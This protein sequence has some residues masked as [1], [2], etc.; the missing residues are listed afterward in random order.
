[1]SRRS[2]PRLAEEAAVRI[3]GMDSQGRPISVATSTLDISRTGVR[4]GGVRC[5]GF[6]GEIIGVRHGTEK[7]RF[8]IVWIGAPG[9]Q[10][11]GQIGLQCVEIGRYIF[12]VTLP[13]T[14]TRPEIA[15]FESQRTGGNQIGMLS[16]QHSGP[17]HR[18]RE[19]RYDVGG[20]VNIREIGVGVPQWAMLHDISTG[21]CYVE[22]TSPLPPL[23]RAELT[24]QVGDYRI[25]CKG[26]VTV[27]HPLVGMGI[28]FTDMTAVNRDR[29]IHLIDSLE[30]QS[31]KA[32]GAF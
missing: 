7:A 27:K 6:P 31:A 20:G 16:Q 10:M 13:S 18:R 2:E 32:A 4:L 14:D 15:S 3:F 29:L 9:T 22:T 5:W 12:S 23:S 26:S 19:P 17:E 21:G 1:M 30:D 25:D 11:E 28:K 24:I 8:R